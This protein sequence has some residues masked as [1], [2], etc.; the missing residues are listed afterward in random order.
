MHK[1]PS[2]YKAT[3]RQKAGRRERPSLTEVRLLKGLTS[4]CEANMMV[5]ILSGMPQHPGE[6]A[7]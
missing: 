6:A 1:T 7:T 3:W 2:P 4:A 5:V